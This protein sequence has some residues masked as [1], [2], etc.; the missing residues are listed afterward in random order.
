M[1]VLSDSK[2]Q[3]TYDSKKSGMY[4][5]A[6]KGAMMI[7]TNTKGEYNATERFGNVTM[8]EIEH[9]RITWEKDATRRYH[10]DTRNTSKNVGARRYKGLAETTPMMSDA[11]TANSDP[12]T[13]I[14]RDVKNEF[15]IVTYRG[16]K[17]GLHIMMV[18]TDPL[19]EV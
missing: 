19:M 14:L 8:K 2:M 5:K 3:T 18:F 11:I 4:E 1:G 6:M 10:T 12:V 9:K 13:T 15:D 17:T 7:K 16:G